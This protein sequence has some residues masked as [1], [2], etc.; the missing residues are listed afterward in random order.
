MAKKKS[1]VQDSSKQ[2][3]WQPSREKRTSTDSDRPRGVS[4]NMSSNGA[5]GASPEFNARVA[6]K[7]YELFERRGGDEGQDVQDWL[8]AERL[9][10]EEIQQEN[11]IR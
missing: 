2:E 8:E 10:R 9:V 1:S 3:S 7:A 5:D 11:L 4:G 6:R